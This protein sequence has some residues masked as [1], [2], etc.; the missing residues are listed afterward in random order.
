MRQKND[1]V[2]IELDRVRE[3]RFGHKALKKL[4]ALTGKSL[5]TF[6]TDS[7]DIEE[8]EKVL[9]CGL[10]SDAKEHGEV[11]KLE[12]MEDLL[13]QAPSYGELM[14]KMQEAFQVAFG[15]MGVEKN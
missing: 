4:M 8:L 9:Y 1:V 15:Q 14:D 13:D 5:D 11:L 6:D 2:L 10:L 3:L 7:F 12:D